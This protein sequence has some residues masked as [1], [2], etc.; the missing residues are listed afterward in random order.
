MRE[1]GFPHLRKS[2]PQSLDDQEEQFPKSLCWNPPH[3][4]CR[5]EI[6]EANFDDDRGDEV[7][8]VADEVGL[9][10]RLVRVSLPSRIETSV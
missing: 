7:S 8:L 6:R 1:K 3:N 9:L 5:V 2:G 4:C 10:F